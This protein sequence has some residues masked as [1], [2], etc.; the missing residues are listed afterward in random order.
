VTF[1]PPVVATGLHARSA[2]YDIV[3]LAHILAVLASLLVV[4][5]AG[6]S[7]LAL[8]RSGPPTDALRRYYRPGTNWAGRVVFLVPVLGAVLVA[9]SQGDWS[10]SD[11]WVL[12]GLVVWLAAAL[13]GEL[14]LWPAERRLR[15][16]VARGEAGGELATDCR[17][18]AGASLAIGVLLIAAT[19]VMVAKP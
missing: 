5:V 15:E 18:A 3:L 16:T 6:G 2:A 1:A 11:D 12:I 7:A 19:V 17:S 10:Y 13:L 9:M 8:G 4:A 14:V